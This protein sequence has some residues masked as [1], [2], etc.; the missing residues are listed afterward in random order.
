MKAVAVFPEKREVG[1]I[2]HPEPRIVEPDQVRIRMLEVGVCGTDQE[3]ISFVLGTAPPG[4]DYLVLGHESLGVVEETG[5]AVSRVKPGDLVVSA[6]R[7]PCPHASC[8]ACRAGH[9]DFCLTG[10]YQERGI[11]ELHGFMTDFVIDQER[12]LHV[13]PPGLRDVGV[14]IEPLTIAEKLFLQLGDIQR[15]LPWRGDR[16]R[17]VVLGAG[18]VGLLGAMGLIQAGFDTWVYS[19]AR[20]PNPKAA[21]AGAIGAAYVSSQEVPLDEFAA[22]VG[23][24]DLVYEAMGAPQIAFDMLKRLGSNGVFVFTGVPRID[25]AVSFDTAPVVLNL[26]VKN[27]V[28]MGTVNAGPAAFDAAVRDLESFLDRWPE[29]V[30][31]L[32]TG[33][34]P[35]EEFRD[36]VFG[37][38]GGIKNVIVL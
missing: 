25:S 26:V 22:R 20:E 17:A 16:Q 30:R 6:V 37:Q 27:Q 23:N 11:K 3:I 32:I 12:Y 33:R 36:P 8:E 24:I 13:I 5:P 28:V 18:P 4:S 21:I 7:H 1:I 19:R 15:R 14:L 2:D 31:S 38:S 34:Y 35:I 29:A 10:D 9:Q